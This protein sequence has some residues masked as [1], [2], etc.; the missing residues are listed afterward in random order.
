MEMWLQIKP[1]DTLLF[2][3]AT[4]FDKGM[5]NIIESR[6]MPYP[7]V[8]YGAICTALME[9]GNLKE[10]RNILIDKEPSKKELENKLQQSLKLKEVYMVKKNELYIPAPMDLFVDK[11]GKPYKGD[12]RDGVLYLAKLCEENKKLKSV[13]GKYINF[14]DFLEEYPRKE[15][16]RFSIYEENFFWSEYQKIGLEIDPKTYK[17]KE[18]YLYHVNMLEGNDNDISYLVNISLPGEVEKI[19]DWKT[20]IF[21]G[22]MA[23]VAF[24]QQKTEDDPN[25]KLIKEYKELKNETDIVKL[26]FTQPVIFNQNSNEIVKK[27]L[28]YSNRKITVIGRAVGK[29]EYI[30]GFDMALKKEKEIQE[31]IPAGSVFLLKSEKFKGCTNKKII[32]FLEEE[33]E[34]IIEQP[35][36]GFGNFLITE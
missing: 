7:S 27:E 19:K 23:R 22:G 10:L 28:P 32:E 3:D 5:S 14:Y 8:L 18:R 9:R 30:G 15:G 26:I 24:L 34:K 20:P 13:Q 1:M 2:R 35:Y 16:A 29:P 25:V 6:R 4:I 36:R 31:G 11:L 17:N 33:L 12:F 21:L